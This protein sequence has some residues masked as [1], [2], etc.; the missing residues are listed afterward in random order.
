MT[1]LDTETMKKLQALTIMSGAERVTASTVA[2]ECIR[3]QQE[4]N[5]ALGVIERV[6]ELGVVLWH[7]PETGHGEE[8]DLQEAVTNWE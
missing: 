8:I 4:L 5:K 7:N 2:S 6:K 1:P 3:L